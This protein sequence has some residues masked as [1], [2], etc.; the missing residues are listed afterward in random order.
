MRE[1]L[2]RIK[3]IFP[4]Y[5]KLLT[6]IMLARLPVPYGFWRR[7]SLF[8]HGAMDDPVTALDTVLAATRAAGLGA[9]LDG[10]SVL[11]LGPGDAL[12]SAVIGTALG[13]RQVTLVD[14]GA[15]ARRDLAPYRQ[16][17]AVLETAGFDAGGLGQA[18]DL[19]D[20]L[21]RCHARYRT[22]G[23]DSL[24]GLEPGSIDFAFS[25]AVLEHIRFASFQE[26]LRALRRALSPSGVAF[27]RVDLQDHLGF[28]LNNLRFG[29]GVWES[30]FM[31]GSG[32]YTNRIRFN[33]MLTHFDQA[34]FTVALGPVSRFAALPTPKRAMARPFRDLDDDELLIK[35]F[36]VVLRPA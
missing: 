36:D 20:L 7:M 2:E 33:A 31:A 18:R 4:W 6:K 10:L 14:T 34:G 1:K 26:T 8:R 21:A 15:F 13:A 17:L 5:L 25:N 30:D 28:A 27:H 3:G 12:T 32:F 29:H 24:K 16:L 9:R 23:L 22:E 11:E 19:D 35:G